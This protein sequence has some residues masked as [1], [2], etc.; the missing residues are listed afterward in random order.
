MQALYLIGQ[1]QISALTTDLTTYATPEDDEASLTQERV[2]PAAL[3]GQIVVSLQGLQRTIDDY[4]NMS[5]NEL[6]EEKR[7]KAQTL[8]LSHPCS[9]VCLPVSR[10]L[11]LVLACARCMRVFCYATLSESYP[12]LYIKP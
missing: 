5:R 1:R 2:D 10:Y 9:A 6:V 4:E 11:C 7:V 3:N 8:V 12:E